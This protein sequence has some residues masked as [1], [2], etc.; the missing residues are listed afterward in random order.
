[1]VDRNGAPIAVNL[2]MPSAYANLK[3]MI[4]PE[5]AATKL[6]QAMPDLKCSKLR[7]RF[8]NNKSF[9]WIKRHLTPREQ[10]I[11][12]NLG[13]PGVEFTKDQKR[14]Y[15]GGKLF[16]H[17]VGYVDIDGNGMAGV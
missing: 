15:P 4:N 9:A 16:S 3:K 7:A 1:V 5:V 14:V 10:Q 2:T 11:I 6:C 13:I 17:V 8:E 12:N